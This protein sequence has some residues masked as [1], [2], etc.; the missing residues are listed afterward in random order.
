[1]RYLPGA[2]AGEAARFLR[3]AL[4]GRLFV[5]TDDFAGDPAASAYG[6]AYSEALA[7]VGS[8]LIDPT[9][10]YLGPAAPRP[11]GSE[12]PEK[13]RDSRPLRRKFARNLGRR[14]GVALYERV[15]RGELDRRGLRRLFTSPLEAGNA[16][17][18]VLR[19]LRGK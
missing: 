15:R 12:K 11:W 7:Y 13:L 4:T 17:R 18:L 2:A 10:D 8:K 6:A 19:L 14:L 9:S 16:E 1:M 3:A 5:K